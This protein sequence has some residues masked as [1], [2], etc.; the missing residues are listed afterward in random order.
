MLKSIE[1]ADEDDQENNSRLKHKP[2]FNRPNNDRRQG[3]GRKPCKKNGHKHHWKNCP[4]NKYVNKHHQSVRHE[5]QHESSQEREI[6]FEDRH[7]SNM[8]EANESE[9]K[10]EGLPNLETL[11]YS[12]SDS[13]DELEDEES[14]DETHLLQRFF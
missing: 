14:V 7:E 6:S 12:D 2:M 5:R 3:R 9:D 8:I 10:F 1:E 4:D 13:E 11:C